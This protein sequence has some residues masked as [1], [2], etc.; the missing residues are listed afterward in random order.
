MV[1]QLKKI[2]AA[3]T[4]TEASLQKNQCQTANRRLE[5]ARKL[6][7]DIQSRYGAKIPAGNAE[8]KVEVERL[9]AIAG[10]VSEANVAAAAAAA[11]Q[12]ATQEQRQA[13]SKEW[14]AKL[15][16]FFD[17]KG[18]LYLRMGAEF[19][20]ASPEEQQKAR[21]A[22]A[23]TADGK[24]Y[25]HAVHLAADRQSDGSWGPLYGHIA[26]SDWMAERNVGEEP[27]IP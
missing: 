21:Q 23:K 14:I 26:W 2:D 12:A 10:R 22:Y 8:M 20:N 4:A 3:V 19:N 17:Y 18:D 1:S 16:S 5:E 27:P 7:A 24:V 11:A 15:S 6:M 13:Q 9:N 25:L